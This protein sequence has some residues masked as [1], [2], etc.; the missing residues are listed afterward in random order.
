M[1]LNIFVKYSECGF[2]FDSRVPPSAEHTMQQSVQIANIDSKSQ[3][4][5]SVLYTEHR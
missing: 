4:V 2:R 1:I 5:S 3:S